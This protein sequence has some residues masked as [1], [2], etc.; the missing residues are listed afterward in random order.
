MPAF[1]HRRPHWGV[2][3]Q[4]QANVDRFYLLAPALL[5]LATFLIAFIVYCGLHVAGRAPHTQD[6]KHNQLFGPFVA[7]FL[8]W[9]LGPLER[10]L[11]GRVAPN[12]IT[13]ASLLL[14]AITGLAVG[15]GHL[16]GAVWLYVFAGILDVL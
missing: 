15:L 9:L 7:K 8:V 10:L 6:V 1:D 11:V 14:C 4:S 3:T 2:L 12:V 5:L 16:P 13:I